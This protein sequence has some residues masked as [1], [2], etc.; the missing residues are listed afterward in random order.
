[1]PTQPIHILKTT[2]LRKH[3]NYPSSIGTAQYYSLNTCAYIISICSYIIF[4]SFLS[5]DR[6]SRCEWNYNGQGLEYEILA[7][8]V[9]IVVYTLASIPI[10]FWA[11]TYSRKNILAAMLFFWSLMTALTGL[12]KEYWHLVILRFALGVGQAGCTP[13]ATSLL[14]DYFQPS[15]RA[16]AIGVYNWGIYFGYSLAYAVGNFVTLA[17][18]QG[19]VVL[20]LVLYILLFKSVYLRIQYGIILAYRLVRHDIGHGDL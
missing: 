15:W 11:D 2:K 4:N 7:G 9:F 19:Q 5:C 8:P 1:M 12:A 3:E 18:I 13:L 10:S 16:T 20:I 17:D 14:T 6:S